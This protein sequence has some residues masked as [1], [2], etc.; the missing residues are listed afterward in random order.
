MADQTF[1]R[2]LNKIVFSYSSSEGLTVFGHKWRSNPEFN[3]DRPIEFWKAQLAFRGLS[4]RGNDV[5]A[6]KERLMG[7]AMKSPGDEVRQVATELIAIH[8]AAAGGTKKRKAGDNSTEDHR[9]NAK[10]ALAQRKETV[11]SAKKRLNDR[12]KAHSEMAKRSKERIYERY[13]EAMEK[14]DGGEGSSRPA[15]TKTPK[16]EIIAAKAP[17]RKERIINRRMAENNPD[18]FLRDAFF[19]EHGKD[20]GY[21]LVEL[22]N[23]CSADRAHL[24]EACD[25]LRLSDETTVTSVMVIGSGKNKQGQQRVKDLN[26]AAGWPPAPY[27]PTI[28]NEDEEGED[29][30]ENEDSS[31]MEGEDENDNASG[32][33]P[34]EEEEN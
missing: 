25:H 6:L 21:P 24:H 2:T 8:K 7:A 17:P 31:E 30:D 26:R 9:K 11:E 34:K 33:E 20:V 28:D 22:K 23:L 10:R 13:K 3:V 12:F 14:G 4:P 32:E 1:Q 29:A 16:Q 27:F 5:A 15:P 19:D 18:K